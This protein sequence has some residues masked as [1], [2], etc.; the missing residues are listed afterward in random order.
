M[1]KDLLQADCTQCAA[2]CCIALAFS[3]SDMFGFDKEAGVPC[4]NL[5]KDHRCTIHKRLDDDGF[6]GC[7]R[8][9]CHGA[10][11]RVTQDLFGGRSW[12]DD[13]EIAVPMFD[14]FRV[15]RQIHDLLLLLVSA[16]K[17]PLLPAQLSQLAD[18]QAK[19]HPE[20]G[21]SLEMLDSFEKTGVAEEVNGFLRG[22]REQASEW[23]RAN[24]PK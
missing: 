6:T 19:L 18:L 16:Q 20:N 3:R 5:D 21:W 13:P 4:S 9:D 1:S 24:V 23:A 12:R 2:L 11:Q 14:A 17:L 7:V 22:L 10:G 8:F 15:M